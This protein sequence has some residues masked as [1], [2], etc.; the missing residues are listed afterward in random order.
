MQATSPVHRNGGFYN[1]IQLLAMGLFYDREVSLVG[2]R[3]A[4]VAGAE[5]RRGPDLERR[6][7]GYSGR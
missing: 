7:V 2:N 3:L 1:G 4:N 6:V 5:P